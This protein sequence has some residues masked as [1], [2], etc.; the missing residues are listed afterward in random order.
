[1]MSE[2][3]NIAI[4]AEAAA[5]LA[6][7][8][9]ERED[10]DEELIADSIEG[11]TSLIEAIDAA[12]DEIDHLEAIEAGCKQKAEMFTDRARR[13][14]TRRDRIKSAIEQALVRTEQKTLRL[15]AATLTLREVKSSVI[16]EDEAAIPSEFWKPQPPKLD[17]KALNEAAKEGKVAGTGMSNGGVAISIRRQ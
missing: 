15:A 4:Q 1:M 5:D 3:R 17:K 8:I 11:E 7:M 2:E 13:A 12:L 14:S 6:A 10:D 9:R 16:I